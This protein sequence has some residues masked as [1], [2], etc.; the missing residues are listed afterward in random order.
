MGGQEVIYSVSYF[1]LKMNVA[2]RRRQVEEPFSV[3]RGPHEYDANGASCFSIIEGKRNSSRWSQR[4]SSALS[5]S[6]GCFISSIFTR[7][8]LN[9][10]PEMLVR[11]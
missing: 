5:R 6:K 11:R 10:M 4:A 7:W 2:W 8:C 1:L 9:L 3:C